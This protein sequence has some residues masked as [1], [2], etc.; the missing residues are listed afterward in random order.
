M[1]PIFVDT[2]FIIVLINQRDKY[3]L[4]AQALANQF[5]DQSPLTTDA[6]LLEV[7]NAL[8]RH[9]RP[10]AIV[11]IQHFLQSPDVEVAYL[12]PD[13]FTVA[14]DLYKEYSDKAWGLV[15]CISFVVMKAYNVQQALTS[16]RHFTQAGFTALMHKD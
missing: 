15:D 1:S 13:R 9:F 2:T 10:Q 7:G 14:F 5:V 6:V 12:T 3:H 8:A 16:D 4:Q 11:I